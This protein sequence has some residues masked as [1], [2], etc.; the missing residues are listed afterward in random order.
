MYVCMYVRMCEESAIQEMDTA[1]K[2]ESEDAQCLLTVH[3]MIRAGDHYSSNTMSD[4]N[5]QPRYSF[6]SPCVI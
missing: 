5:N 1:Q 6:P 4:I 3:K 2:S